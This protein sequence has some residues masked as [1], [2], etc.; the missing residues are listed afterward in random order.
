[1]FVDGTMENFTF[2]VDFKNY[3]LFKLLIKLQLLLLNADA[4]LTLV[5]SYLQI[6]EVFFVYARVKVAYK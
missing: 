3:F 1:M 2:L 5:L 4:I 6:T